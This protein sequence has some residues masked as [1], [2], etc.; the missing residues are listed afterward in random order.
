MWQSAGTTA[1]PLA[2]AV[3]QSI[4]HNI[5]RDA[6]GTSCKLAQ[7]AL[8]YLM[9]VIGIARIAAAMSQPRL[10]KWAGRVLRRILPPGWID[11]LTGNECICYR[12][13]F[14]SII[15][16]T[17][18]W[19]KVLVGHPG[20]YVGKFSVSRADVGKTQPSVPAR[21]FEEAR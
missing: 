3:K 20:L 6:S 12:H 1:N 2:V 18:L 15:D 17:V 21:C 19:E 8:A 7:L 16:A 9:V 14:R 13:R 10:P 11:D 5:P 4:V